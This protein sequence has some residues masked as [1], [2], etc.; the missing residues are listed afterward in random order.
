MQHFVICRLIRTEIGTRASPLTVTT[1]ANLELLA[2]INFIKSNFV[3]YIRPVVVCYKPT[4]R[5]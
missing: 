4:I 1:H 3:N 5:R 2:V